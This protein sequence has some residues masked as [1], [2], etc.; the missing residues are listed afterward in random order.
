VG[1]VRGD[2][3]GDSRK[4]SECKPAEQDAYARLVATLP[5][6]FGRFR[7][8]WPLIVGAMYPRLEDSGK[9][10]SAA[11]RW[12][13]F[14]GVFEA[15]GLLRSWEVDG[16]RYAELTGWKPRK[17]PVYHRTPEPPWKGHEHTGWCL[18]S[19]ITRQKNAGLH[20]IAADLSIQLKELRQRNGSG[21]HSG[22]G[23]GE[24]ANPSIPSP[25]SLPSPPRER[26]TEQATTPLPPAS[27]GD[28]T[29]TES[30]GA[31]TPPTA[32][33]AS[34]P[35]G[36]LARVLRAMDER[37]PGMAA[38]QFTHRAVRRRLRVVSA[39]ALLAEVASWPERWT[40]LPDW[41]LSRDLRERAKKLS[42]GLGGGS[43]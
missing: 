13:R 32:A 14:V 27:G 5:D 28:Q 4:L 1:V 2:R 36:D 11:E 8:S 12:K 38:D 24:G 15:R 21:R 17:N 19:A 33:E 29:G 6:D 18:S 23:S 3:I 10:R 31:P 26:K 25:P 43:R 42:H 22:E 40:D 7:L 37:F 20:Q 16:V 39:T 41:V 30:D 9:V 35:S 34:Q